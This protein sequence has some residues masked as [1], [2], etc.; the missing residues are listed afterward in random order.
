[1][2]TVRPDSAYVQAERTLF[3]VSWGNR[4]AVVRAPWHNPSSCVQLY[5]SWSPRARLL[6]IL[7]CGFKGFFA[8]LNDSAS[9]GFGSRG[10]GT[11]VSTYISILGGLYW[12]LGIRLYMLSSSLRFAGI[13]AVSRSK[14]KKSWSKKD[15]VKLKGLWEEDARMTLNNRSYFLVFLFAL[16]WAECIGLID[17]Y[18]IFR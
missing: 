11:V 6:W 7:T 13:L 15:E 2:A 8:F 14:I 10:P 5:P 1:M 16:T 4:L 12:G 18:I 9:R 17:I 3:R